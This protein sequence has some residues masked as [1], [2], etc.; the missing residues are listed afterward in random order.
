M[1]IIGINTRELTLRAAVLLAAA[2][3]CVS[4][5]LA[6]SPDQQGQAQQGQSQQQAQPGNSSQTNSQ[7][8]SQTTSQTTSQTSSQTNVQT[9]APDPLKPKNPDGTDVNPALD[10]DQNPESETVSSADSQITQIG[11]ANPLST[12]GRFRWGPLA[13][14]ASDIRGAV[15]LI[16]PSNAAEGP[17]QTNILSLFETNIVLDQRFGR[18]RL[19][20]QYSPRVAISNG[21]VAYDYLNQNFAIDSYYLLGSRWSLSLRDRFLTAS[22]SGLQ[23]GVFADANAITSTTLQNDFLDN[24]ET[25]LTNSA[26]ATLSY[27]VSPRT[28]LTF[29]PSVDYSRTSGLNPATT[30]NNGTNVSGLNSGAEVRVQHLISPLTTIGAYVSLRFVQFNGFLPASSY[31]TAGFSLSHQLTATTGFNLNLGATQTVFSGQQKYWET[32]GSVAFFKTFQRSRLSILYTRGQPAAG[33]VTNYLSQRVDG[34]LHVLVSPRMSFDAGV[35][36]EGELS[37]QDKVSGT[38]VTGGAEY[39]LGP[40]W[41]VFSSFA[42]KYQ[43]SNNIQLFAGTREF[44]SLGLR[45]YPN[46][47]S[48]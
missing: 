39:L 43:V 17:S 21:Q 12:A 45:W 9:P 6:Q 8:S 37:A 47:G 41:S 20:L 11:T 2:M 35:G 48:R 18:N 23:G 19:A 25:F 5:A 40:T 10:Q 4:P 32:T 46:A 14:G 26:S 24:R 3:L 42:Y 30:L 15:D 33:Y 27:G 38:Y 36:Y 16:R 7:T 34:I 1:M 29:S 31:Y 22:N 28:V 13:L 44:A